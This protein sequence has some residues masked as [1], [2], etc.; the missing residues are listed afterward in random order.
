MTSNATLCSTW[1]L[2]VI[3]DGEA[4]GAR[5]PLDVAAAAIRGGAD[6]LQLRLKTASTREC[7]T[8]GQQM[9]ALARPAGVPLIINDRVDVAIAVGADGVHL[10]QEDLPPRIARTLVGPGRLIG[11]STHSL[12]QALTAQREPIDYFGVGPIFSTPTKPAYPSVGVGLIRQVAAAARLPFVCIGGI[13]AQTLPEVRAAGARCVAVVRAVCAASD[14]E[15]A[16]RHLKHLLTDSADK[17][18]RLRL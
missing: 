6:V 1:R 5:S 16:T 13:D 11:L 7:I 8:R 15:S 10:G 18:Q 12:E 3:I 2:Y 14:P 4:I 9:L 17:T